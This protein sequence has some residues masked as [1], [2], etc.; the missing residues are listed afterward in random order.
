MICKI[1]V[2]TSQE[3]HSVSVT[4]MNRLKLFKETIAVFYENGTKH[5]NTFCRQN[6]EF[7]TLGQVVRTATTGGLKG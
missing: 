7:S 2:R 1:S 5:T 6:A 4:K 3:T